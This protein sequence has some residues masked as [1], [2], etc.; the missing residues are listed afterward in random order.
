[1]KHATLFFTLS[2]ALGLVGTVHAQYACPSPPVM[3][4]QY[5]AQDQP[6]PPTFDADGNQVQLIEPAPGDMVPS[7]YVRP[8]DS[9]MGQDQSM[10]SAVSVVEI[11]WGMPAPVDYGPPPA[12]QDLD[13]NGDGVISSDEAAAYPL[14]GNDFLYAA[15]HGRT[16][17][18]S[19]YARW[20]SH[21]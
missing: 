8:R 10:A 19:Q 12:F 13:T 3:E 14:L 2:L 11:N 15:N 18:R 5:M 17:N 4:D 6:M 1:M 20:A 7:P 21:P 16:I 9:D